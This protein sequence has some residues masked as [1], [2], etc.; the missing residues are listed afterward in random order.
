MNE[1]LRAVLAP[2]GAV[3]HLLVAVDFDGTL[4]PLA[5]EPM[6]VQPV[7]GAMPALHALAELDDV[8]VALVS[9]RA[10]EPLQELSAAEN[11]I[12]LIGSHGAESSRAQHRVLSAHEQVRFDRLEADLQVLLDEHPRARIEGK[13]TALVLHTRG[14]PMATAQAAST[15]AVALATTHNGVMLTRG[16]DVVELAVTEADKGSA[17]LDLA[18]SVGANVIVYAGD[19]VTDERAFAELREHDISVKV[20]P[21]STVARYRVKNEHSVVAMLEFLLAV[22]M[23][24]RLPREQSPLPAANDGVSMQ[25]RP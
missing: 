8:T 6:D 3:E 1:T 19:D 14:L 17:L 13:P 15:A 11:S 7:T 18:E 24:A 22:R 25:R 10:L 9:G 5:D 21:G 16:K 2:L 4:A 23:A 20:G 12:I